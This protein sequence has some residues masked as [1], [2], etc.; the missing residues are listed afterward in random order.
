[1]K[2]LETR[3]IGA[4]AGALL[5]LSLCIGLANSASASKTA[6]GTR[7]VT[8]NRPAAR[9]KAPTFRLPQGAT[10]EGDLNLSQDNILDMCK[11]AIP[12]FTEGASSAKGDFGDFMK[13]ADF[14]EL[15]D[16]IKQIKAVRVIDFKMHKRIPNEKMMAFFDKQAANLKGWDR[17]L[18]AMNDKD[19]SV[20]A[21]YCNGSKFMGVAL[22]PKSK[23]NVIFGTD[24][25]IDAKKLFSWIG[26][27]VAAGAD[28]DAA[29]KAAH[30]KAKPT[31]A[32][33]PQSVP[34]SNVPPLQPAGLP[35]ANPTPSPAA[36]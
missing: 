31:D 19:H 7:A 27:V 8:V 6:A 24:G 28:L 30:P 33:H 20:V 3:T 14:N 34:N 15:Y 12:A 11:G 13:K 29:Q 25:F 22:D 4:Y 32:S 23:S 5:V 9:L 18:Y 35:P 16:S 36:E 21:V 10:I 17:I 26:K 2:A 1:M